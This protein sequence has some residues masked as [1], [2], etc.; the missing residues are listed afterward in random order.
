MLHDIDPST[1]RR[2]AVLARGALGERRE[3]IDALNVFPVPDGDT[4]TNLY[5]TL[6]QGFDR[7]RAA[8]TKRNANGGPPLSVG[9]QTRILADATLLTARGNSGVI[10][11]QMVRGFAESFD[12]V[13]G[14]ACAGPVEVARGL[15]R[16]A[17]LAHACVQ[18]PV[19]GTILTVAADSATAAVAAADTDG[20]LGEVVG[21][22]VEAAETSL[23]E[24]PSLLPA[25]KDAGVVDAGG[26]GYLLLLEILDHVVR[27]TDERRFRVDDFLN[28]TRLVTFTP[29]ATAQDPT[30]VPAGVDYEV[31]YLIDQTDEARIATLKNELDA[32]GEA[33]IVVG[34]PQLWNVHVHLE[35]IG[36]AIERGIEAGR[37]HRIRVGPLLEAVHDRQGP[38]APVGVVACAA[39]PGLADLF[40]SAGAIAVA[41]GPGQRASAGEL[42]DAV[43]ASHAVDVLL[44]PNDRDT[45]LAAQAAARA[46]ADDGIAVH[47]IP[48]TTAVQG[49]AALVVYDP[50]ADPMVNQIAMVQAS[51]QTHHGAVSTAVKPGL[52]SGGWCEIGDILGIVDGDITLIGQDTTEVALRVLERLLAGGGELVTLIRGAG[53]G[54]DL[55]DDVVRELRS[56]HFGLEVEVV[57]GGQPHYE[58]LIGVE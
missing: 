29:T 10:L 21:A 22:A 12:E 35:D 23:A 37:P 9:E 11:S 34:G 25:L 49:M 5:L 42:L 33:V 7:V 56:A 16:A 14:A 6:D 27:D 20:T 46:A 18:R 45:H 24:T 44:L 41:S 1:V 2:W 32:I 19:A 51:A 48:S 13:E 15:T 40:E 43:H 4:G 26:A 31:M 54:D 58:L 30:T 3:R 28:Q 53:A 57:D 38:P 8:H 17:E 50:D 39:G 52:T 47:V 55:V 36:A